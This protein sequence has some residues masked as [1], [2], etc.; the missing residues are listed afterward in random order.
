MPKQLRQFMR[1]KDVAE[2]TCIP[3]STIYEMISRG[4]FPKPFKI[5][6]KR[7]AWDAADIAEWQANVKTPSATEVTEGG[8]NE[9]SSAQLI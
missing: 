2:F 5:T 4:E 9:R 1:M 3:R 8:N 6:A 7:V